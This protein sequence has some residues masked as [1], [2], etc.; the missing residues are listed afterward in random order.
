MRTWL[1][2]RDL[3]TA[4]RVTGWTDARRQVAKGLLPAPY[5]LGPQVRAWAEDEIADYDARLQ[6]RDYPPEKSSGRRKAAPEPKAASASPR[7]RSRPER[8]R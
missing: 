7:P 1:R 5:Q 2:L 8:P 6:K 3:K 4:G